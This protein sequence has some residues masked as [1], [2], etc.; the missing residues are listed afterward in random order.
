[1]VGSYFKT[2]GE[3]MTCKD[4]EYHDNSTSV[5]GKYFCRF[6]KDYRDP[7]KC[8]SCKHDTTKKSSKKEYV[9]II[10]PICHGNG[11]WCGSE[12][13]K[14]YNSVDAAL[15][16]KPRW[17]PVHSPYSG[18]VLN[19]PIMSLTNDPNDAIYIFDWESDKW[20]EVRP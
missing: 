13:V 16:T 6:Y 4:C 1:M 17:R 11:G 19:E 14:E 18:E 8:V 7:T 20:N 15:K 9:Y 10:Q 3:P 12:I 2:K 5:F